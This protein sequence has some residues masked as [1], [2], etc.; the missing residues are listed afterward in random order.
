MNFTSNDTIKTD[1]N[2]VNYTRV[3]PVVL[4][5]K[6]FIF[7]PLSTRHRIIGAIKYLFHYSFA[8]SR[9]HERNIFFFQRS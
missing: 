6:N 8:L 2:T 3:K 9:K 5:V 4:Q 7:I 1:T